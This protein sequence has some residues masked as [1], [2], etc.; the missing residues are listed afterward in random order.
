MTKEKLEETIHAFELCRKM[1]SMDL[2]F[3][4]YDID[5]TILY[6]YPEDG[7]E[8]GIYLGQKFEDETGGLQKVLATGEAIHNFIPLE[9]F[10]FE[11]EGNVVPVFD[12]GVVVGALSTA[13]IPMNQNQLAAQEWA[14]QTVY[15]QILTIDGR[16][17]HYTTL[18]GGIAGEY[19]SQ[20]TLHYGSF[21]ERTAENIHT[22]CR[23]E[24]LSFTDL[25][26]LKDNLSPGEIMSLDCRITSGNNE[27]RW[28]EISIK[29]VTD[30]NGDGNTD[31]F[32]YM[33]RDIH[34]SK[35]IEME[36]LEE[37]RRLI[38]QLKESNAALFE[39]NMR[40][41]LTGLY[42]RKG[43]QHFTQFLM[44]HSKE[45]DL[46][47]FAMVADLNGLKA[48][49]DKYGHEEGDKAIITIADLLKKS[50]VDTS[51]VIR[52]GGDEFII[53]DAFEKESDIPQRVAENF[54]KN[55]KEY[56]ERTRS[57]YKIHASFGCAFIRAIDMSDIEVVTKA[58]D[59]EM[60]RMKSKYYENHERDRRKH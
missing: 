44:S 53:L 32:L 24:Y 5:T 9:R 14:L 17:N 47:V 20:D 36:I 11:M 7:E 31:T 2:F 18:F 34:K 23:E 52:S 15:S 60:Y 33:V 16:H 6:M 30:Y 51:I 4:I 21:C 35:S 55:M 59:E 50:V 25:E 3:C 57:L 10:G 22:D 12:E 43:M 58:A 48:I 42:N 45:K 39:L 40:D 1:I 8:D 56:N 13:Y 28:H 26:Y 27:Y 41:G 54:K 49:N 19:L 38:E 29:R 46:Y 37:N